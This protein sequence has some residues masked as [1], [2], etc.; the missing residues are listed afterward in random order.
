[1]LGLS[2]LEILDISKNKITAL[3]EN[4][5]RMTSLKFLGLTQNR[6]TRLPVSMG[7]MQSLARLKFDDN[8]L[9][10]P[11]REVY[12]LPS[13]PS[14]PAYDPIKYVCT[15]VKKFLREFAK[16]QAKAAADDDNSES[17][18]ETPRPARRTIG[19]RFPVRP[20]ISGIEGLGDLKLDSARMPPPPIPQRSQARDS[21]INF[22]SNRRPGLAPLLTEGER[23]RSRSETVTSTASNSS[24]RSKRLGYV[25]R[26]TSDAALFTDTGTLKPKHFRGAS[27]A[28]V[29]SILQTSSGGETSSGPGS[30]V[31]GPTSRSAISSRR[32]SSLPEARRASKSGHPVVKLARR[33]VFSLYQLNAPIDNVLRVIR[34]GTPKKSIA[35]RAHFAAMA[36]V[37]ELDRLLHRLAD[38]TEED[39]DAYEDINSIKALL[40]KSIHCMRSYGQVATELRLNA[41]KIVFRGEP[42]YIRSM[43]LQVYGSLVEIRNAL[44]V[45]EDSILDKTPVRTQRT[46]RAMSSRSVTPTQA[47]PLTNRRI[48]GATILQPGGIDNVQPPVP[49]IS[50]TNSH[51]GTMTSIS[52]A[53]PTSAHGESFSG[54]VSAPMSRSNTMQSH[55]DEMDDERQFER[56]YLKLQNA[57]TMAEQILPNCRTDIAMRKEGAARS[58]NVNVTHMWTIA[59]QKS[60]AAL[61]ALQSLKEHLSVVKLKDPALRSQ[62]DFWRLCDTFVRVRTILSHAPIFPPRDTDQVIELHGSSNRNQNHWLA[63]PRRAQHQD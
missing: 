22:P 15:E 11:P 59:Y 54:L 13:A 47:K 25:P 43:M 23:N 41:R 58:M 18:A 53:T 39:N 2:H 17:N 30:P 56:I 52:T 4:I 1:M 48:R 32:L 36:Q 51:T 31:D 45:L 19:G 26:K 34:G 10:F 3:P 46:S 21:I 55:V 14:S 9:E 49:L 60:E 40:R 33:I 8:P 27:H 16:E 38:R 12:T 24:H 28:S 7:E 29:I 44:S 20:S 42:M 35:E 63:W 6:V 50:G 5:N 62:Q 57:C 37:D 61:N